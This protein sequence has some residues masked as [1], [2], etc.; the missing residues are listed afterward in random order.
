MSSASPYNIEGARLALT[1]VSLP[2]NIRILTTNHSAWRSHARS[3]K[4]EDLRALGLKIDY[5]DDKPEVAKIIYNIK[6]VLMILFLNTSV[7]KIFA[8]SENTLKKYTRKNSSSNDN[9]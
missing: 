2:K 9:P 3:I 4:I 1:T 7:Y 6:A 8:D 5:I